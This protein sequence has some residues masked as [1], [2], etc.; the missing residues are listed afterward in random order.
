MTEFIKKTTLWWN[1]V[2]GHDTSEI[3][4]YKLYMVTN[5]K[6][7]ERDFEG[8]VP[9]AQVFDLGKPADVSGKCETNLAGLMNMTTND[10]IYNLG[11]ATIDNDGNES[12]FYLMSDV[13]LDFVAPDAPSSA[14]I[15]RS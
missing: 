6:P 9:D 4:G 2:A 15:I 11:I 8:N 5:D 7:M 1:A 13:P 10:G 12:S 3:A 14:G